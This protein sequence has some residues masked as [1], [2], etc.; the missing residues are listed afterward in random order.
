MK[1][2][3]ILNKDE[4]LQAENEGK[5]TSL[6]AIEEGNVDQD[7]KI[8]DELLA[9]KEVDTPEDPETVKASQDIDPVENT[10]NDIAKAGNQDDSV[11]TQEQLD[12][13]AE[14]KG[15]KETKKVL[16]K[17]YKSPID[18]IQDGE[19]IFECATAPLG[20]ANIAF[21]HNYRGKETLYNLQLMDKRYV[22]P[23]DL[24]KGL[25][26]K[27]RIALIEQYRQALRDNGF[28]DVS[29]LASG[30]EVNVETGEW[31]FKAFHPEHQAKNP[32]NGN[33]GL[34]ILDKNGKPKMVDG[35]P[36]IE[37]VPI[38][39]G[40]AR[41]KDRDVFNA[42]LEAGLADCGKEPVVEEE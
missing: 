2:D 9:E 14:A 8:M 12:K 11:V 23:E 30:T 5:E 37:Q 13:E 19:M 18:I 35:K 39:N 29:L 27:E 10:E 7:G 6:S 22:I 31:T 21:E 17:K 20:E 3:K 33:I 32:I 36:L 38:V 15:S 28:I 26:K 4:N 34:G 24:G 40:I 25:T 1:E 42:L 41:T 16:K